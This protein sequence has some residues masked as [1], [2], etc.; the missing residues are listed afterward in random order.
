MSPPHR[1]EVMWDDLCKRVETAHDAP[2]SEET[3]RALQWVLDTM[4]SVWN[5]HRHH[6][7]EDAGSPPRRGEDG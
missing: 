7:G 2:V 3:A 6:T 5:T 1:Y 4:D